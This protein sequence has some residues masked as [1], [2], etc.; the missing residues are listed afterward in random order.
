[1]EQKHFTIEFWKRKLTIT[2]SNWRLKI[3]LCSRP[4]YTLAELLSECDASAPRSEQDSIWLNINPVGREHDADAFGLWKDR[5]FDGV[6]YQRTT[7]EE[8][9]K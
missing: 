2:V 5:G 3:G 4:R 6:E 8:W 9:V 1:M 7:R